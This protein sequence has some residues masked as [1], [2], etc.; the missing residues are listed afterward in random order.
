MREH[1]LEDAF[2]D[3]GCMPMLFR[4]EQCEASESVL[5]IDRE[6]A[7]VRDLVTFV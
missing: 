7:Y 4:E 3:V 6:H 1:G 2:P 5:A